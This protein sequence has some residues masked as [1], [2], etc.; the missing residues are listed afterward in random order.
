[1]K[2]KK[3]L[4]S[5]MVLGA[6][7]AGSQIALGETLNATKVADSS[8]ATKVGARAGLVD[9]DGFGSTFG[10]GG[11]SEIELSKGLSIRPSLDYW[12]KTKS[13]NFGYAKVDMTLSD[14]AIGGAVK[15]AFSLP[16]AKVQPYVL[17]GLALH[18]LSAEVKASSGAYEGAVYQTEAS[19]TKMGFDLGGGVA[20]PFSREM[21]VSAELMMRSVDAADLTTIMGGLSYSI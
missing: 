17:G 2:N 5:V 3:Q 1:M 12:Q 7:L 21:E 4:L 6:T 10:V 9:I 19:E 15:Y 13:E 20:Y 8:N 14:L 11:Y 18:R 16:G